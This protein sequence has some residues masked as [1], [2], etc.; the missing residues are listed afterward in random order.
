MLRNWEQETEGKETLENLRRRIYLLQQVAYENQKE[1]AE[2]QQRN[3]NA[4][5]QEHRFKVGDIVI[6]RKENREEQGV[7]GKLNWNWRGPYKIA[8]VVGP[9]TYRLEDEN[10]KK[11]PGTAHSQNLAKLD[12]DRLC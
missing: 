5:A 1:A 2:I 11:I 9:V 12:S 7:I 10:G 3:H 4:H 8:E 6:L